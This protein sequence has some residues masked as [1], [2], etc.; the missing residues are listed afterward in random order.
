MN[1][2]LLVIMYVTEKMVQVS[3]LS[4]PSFPSTCCLVRR[5]PG[6]LR[7]GFVRARGLR[8][9]FIYPEVYALLSIPFPPSRNN[10][11]LILVFGLYLKN[12]DMC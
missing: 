10:L 3:C 5:D 8:Y 4:F 7:P 1:L 11:Q 9:G 12:R 6:A 2:T